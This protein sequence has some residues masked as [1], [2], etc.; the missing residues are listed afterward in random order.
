MPTI[1]WGALLGSLFGFTV[2][3]NVVHATTTFT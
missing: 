1:L 2:G 3:F